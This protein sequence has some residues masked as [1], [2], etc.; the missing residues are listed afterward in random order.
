[1]RP[2][3]YLFLHW[4]QLLSFLFLRFEYRPTSSTTVGELLADLILYLN[5]GIPDE[6][7][8]FSNQKVLFFGLIFCMVIITSIIYSIL[9]SKKLLRVNSVIFFLFWL[10][11]LYVACVTPYVSISIFLKSSIVYITFLLGSIVS[12]ILLRRK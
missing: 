11:F 1:M 7:T 4:L 12:E 8:P 10:V 9:K 2:K 3:I 6:T 5:S